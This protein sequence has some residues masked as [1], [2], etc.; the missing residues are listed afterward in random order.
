MTSETMLYKN[1]K[2]KENPTHPHT[3]VSRN[4]AAAHKTGIVI[5][6]FILSVSIATQPLQFAVCRGHQWPWWSV[7]PASSHALASHNLN[8]PPTSPTFPVSF[9]YRVFAIKGSSK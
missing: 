8:S 1:L 3:V 7:A 6:T 2:S 9:L 5:P 4:P